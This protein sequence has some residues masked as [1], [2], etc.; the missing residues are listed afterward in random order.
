[1]VNNFFKQ[2]P[3]DK[4]NYSAAKKSAEEMQDAHRLRMEHGVP[5]PPPPPGPRVTPWSNHICCPINAYLV[6]RFPGRQI[7][8]Q[9]EFGNAALAMPPAR[10]R[11][12]TNGGM[13]PSHRGTRG[14]APQWN[15]TSAPHCRRGTGLLVAPRVGVRS[16]S[17][18]SSAVMQLSLTFSPFDDVAVVVYC[19]QVQLYFEN[20]RKLLTVRPPPPPGGPPWFISIS[21]T[22]PCRIVRDQR[23]AFWQGWRGRIACSNAW[24][25]KSIAP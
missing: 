12:W 21:S 10:V 5:P 24:G 15:T 20:P 25:R 1:M 19:A 23:K 17:V 11:Q 16:V 22:T 2:G 8:P 18:P 4:E 14:W 7:S 9:E 3:N 6:A 13:C